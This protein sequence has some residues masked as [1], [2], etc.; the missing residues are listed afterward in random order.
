MFKQIELL[1]EEEEHIELMVE[2]V[3]IFHLNAML[4][5]GLLKNKL[6]LRSKVKVNKLPKVKFQLDKNEC[7]IHVIKLFN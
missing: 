4:K 3:H 5:C 7:L 6:M 1:R 2:L